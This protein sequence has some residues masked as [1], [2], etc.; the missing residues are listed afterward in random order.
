MAMKYY[1]SAKVVRLTI[2][3]SFLYLLFPLLPAVFIVTASHTIES[4]RPDAVV[5][6]EARLVAEEADLLS[7]QHAL[8]AEQESYWSTARLSPTVLCYAGWGWGARLAAIR[9]SEPL[10]A[11]RFIYYRY[12]LCPPSDPFLL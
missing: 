11:L 2:G 6:L 10:A 8:A 1:L 5:D 3:V 4:D 7:H 12:S 9:P